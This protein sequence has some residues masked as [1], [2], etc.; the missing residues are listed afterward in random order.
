ME[1]GNTQTA[2]YKDVFKDGWKAN[3]SHWEI[4]ESAGL[5]V[6]LSPQFIKEFEVKI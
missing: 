4:P 1:E 6:D 5:G 3:L 2:Q